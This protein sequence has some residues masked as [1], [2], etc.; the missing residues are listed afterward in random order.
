MLQHC[1]ILFLLLLHEFNNLGILMSVKYHG[2]VR[3]IGILGNTFH[4]L[5]KTYTL[6]LKVIDRVHYSFKELLILHK[7]MASEFSM[8]NFPLHLRKLV[9][10]CYFKRCDSLYGTSYARIRSLGGH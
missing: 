1:P 3:S 8:R 2:D 9:N 4:S 10:K 7:S 6:N 5:I